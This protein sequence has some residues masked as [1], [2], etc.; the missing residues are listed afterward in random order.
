[1]STERRAR[2]ARRPARR[3]LRHRV[4][5]PAR[6]QLRTGLD[7]SPPPA[8][9]PSPPP[10]PPGSQPLTG[11]PGHRRRPSTCPI[12]T[13]SSRPLRRNRPRPSPS[14]AP[15][16][17]SA[18]A[19]VAPQSSAERVGGLEQTK[20]KSSPW[21]RL[22]TVA[23]RVK[24]IRKIAPQKKLSS[25]GSLSQHKVRGRSP[26]LAVVEGGNVGMLHGHTCLTVAACSA[27]PDHEPLNAKACI[28]RLV[29]ELQHKAAEELLAMKG[30]RHRRGSLRSQRSELTRQRSGSIS[31]NGDYA[32]QIEILSGATRKSERTTVVLQQTVQG[33]KS[34]AAVLYGRSFQLQHAERSVRWPTRLPQ[35]STRP[36]AKSAR[37]RRRWLSLRSN[38][39]S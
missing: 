23:H 35:P 18:A 10:S 15:A 30:G 1:M 29:P 8:S 5:R 3:Q 17:R 13:R 11:R 19:Q 37:S 27:G 31:S 14:D 34:H 6:R 25:D 22:S 21:R 39:A 33:D 2:R 12:R 38:R 24:E 36:T 9:A 28:F 7:A 32:K 16:A 4:R 20:P 26:L